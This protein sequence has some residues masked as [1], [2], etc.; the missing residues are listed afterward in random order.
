VMQEGKTPADVC[1][2]NRYMS[3]ADKAANKDA[4]LA[5]LERASA[6][7]KVGPRSLRHPAHPSPPP[8]V[9]PLSMQ[10]AATTSCGHFGSPV[11]ECLVVFQ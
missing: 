1:C 8:Q 6:A 3:A 7:R 4:V 2:A 9:Q 11:F 10:V 5:A